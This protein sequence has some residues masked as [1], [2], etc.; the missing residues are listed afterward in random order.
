MVCRSLRVLTVA[1][2]LGL[3][4]S[5][6]SAQSAV[7]EGTVVDHCP[8]PVFGLTSRDTILTFLSDSTVQFFIRVV[9]ATCDN[10]LARDSLSGAYAVSRRSTRYG[11]FRVTKEQAQALR[12][13]II[14]QSDSVKSIRSRPRDQ[15]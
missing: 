10:P 7:S 9:P 14:E 13:W 5:E 15:R 1:C 11:P 12:R 8:M 2:S 3:A 6:L 4:G